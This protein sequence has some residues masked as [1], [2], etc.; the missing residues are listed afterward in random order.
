[1]NGFEECGGPAWR[2]KYIA[3]TSRLYYQLQSALTTVI[4]V[5]ANIL[6]KL[7]EVGAARRVESIFDPG[8][9]S[10]LP[11]DVPSVAL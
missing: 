9:S 4:D 6:A 3:K 1:L 7:L 8:V 11:A 5:I 2:L 10:I